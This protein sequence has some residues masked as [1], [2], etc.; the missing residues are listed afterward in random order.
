MEFFNI[1][2]IVRILVALGLGFL[3]GLERELTKS[4]LEIV[5][6]GITQALPDFNSLM[7]VVVRRN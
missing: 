4:H 6:K 5:E 1:E 2:F 7:Y 3:L